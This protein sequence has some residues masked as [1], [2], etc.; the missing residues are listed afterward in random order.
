[1]HRFFIDKITTACKCVRKQFYGLFSININIYRKSTRFFFLCPLMLTY[2]THPFPFIH[3]FIKASCKFGLQTKSTSKRQKYH[4][5]RSTKILKCFIYVVTSHK[6]G[7][8]TIKCEIQ[9]N[10]RTQTQNG[11]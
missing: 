5:I 11:I 10:E 9:M 2:E 1:M 8:N 3:S 4:K 6:L 7:Q